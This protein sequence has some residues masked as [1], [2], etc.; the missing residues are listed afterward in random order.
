MRLSTQ[1]AANTN[2]LYT[3]ALDTTSGAKAP[4]FAA[5][6]GIFIY[7]LNTNL[8]LG[9]LYQPLILG[10]DGKNFSL[11]IARIPNKESIYKKIYTDYTGADKTYLG[12]TC[13]VYQCGSGITGYQGNN[14][15]HSSISI[16][17]VFSPDGGKTLQAFKGDATSDAVGI[18]FGKLTADPYV[19]SQTRYFY[20]L[21]NQY[22][23]SV[24]CTG[25]LCSGYRW[26]YRTANGTQ[27]SANRQYDLRFDSLGANWSNIQDT[28]L[29]NPTIVNSGYSR[30]DVNG[31]PFTVPTTQ[32]LPDAMYENGRWISTTVPTD[33]SIYRPNAPSAINNLGSAVIDGMLI[34]HM[35]ITT[36]GL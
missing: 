18:S 31:T 23:K 4:T 29:Y 11:E 5:N 16:G 15:T 7:N 35:K 14:A 36:K 12:S 13:N 2:N 30:P 34:Q 25:F 17:T 28:G 1:E 21:Q 20:Q 22:R 27:T 8:V 26:E 33:T 10:S 3:P 24:G 6:E 32:P 9:S 19:T